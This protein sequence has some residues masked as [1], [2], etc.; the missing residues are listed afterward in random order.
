M[1]KTVFPLAVAAPQVG[2]QSE[3]FIR[4]HMENLL[5]DSTVILTGNISGPYAGHWQVAA[6]TKVCNPSLPATGVKGKIR[7]Y[8]NKRSIQQFLRDHK[9]DVILG[10]YLNYSY[11]YFLL[12]QEFGI[13]YF[14][15]A[16]GA[17]IS[18]A[19]REPQWQKAYP[20]YQDSAGLITMSAASRNRLVDLGFAADKVHVIPYGVNVPDEPIQRV[21]KSF[22]SCLAVGRM[23]PKKAPIIL[24][25]AFRQASLVFPNLRLDYVGAGALLPAAKQYIHVFGLDGKVTLHEGLPNQKVQELMREADIFLQ[26]SMTDPDSG[27]EEG[28]PVAILEAMAHALP[29]VST[30]HAG[31]PEAVEQDK[32]GFLFAEGDFAGMAQGIVDLAKDFELRSEMGSSGW[33]RA[34]DRFTWERER[35]DLLNVLGLK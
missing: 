31:I 34:K 20:R 22:V 4:R 18:A 7:S 12:A 35:E 24:L 11:G 29:V 13:P 32:T 30:F 17:D 14:A 3:T 16:H 28:L 23:V 5:P 15:H 6:P 2:A 33:Q 10:E 27:D 1:K 9:V 19:L 26:H 8:L 25:E 21:D